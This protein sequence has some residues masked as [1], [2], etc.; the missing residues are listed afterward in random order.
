MMAGTGLI[1]RADT[2]VLVSMIEW[3]QGKTVICITGFRHGQGAIAVSLAA[4]YPA[5]AAAADISPGA[6]WANIAR[7]YGVQ[8]V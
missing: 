5:R 7:L 1:P 8:N 2:E 6:L 3:T 4:L